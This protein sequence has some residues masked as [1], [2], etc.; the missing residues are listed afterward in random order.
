[1]K[2]T[3]MQSTMRVDGAYA[4]EIGEYAVVTEF[5]EVYR[6]PFPEMWQV[7]E[8]QTDGKVEVTEDLLDLAAMHNSIGASM[9]EDRKEMGQEEFIDEDADGQ[10]VIEELMQN[11]PQEEPP[12]QVTVNASMKHD[13]MLGWEVFPGTYLLE[14]GRITSRIPGDEVEPAEGEFLVPF[15]AYFYA[16][17]T[18]EKLRIVAESEKNGEAGYID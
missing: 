10:W 3:I 13:G 5:G 1:M 2:K 9:D 7:E 18:A 14:N 4:V 12:T 16:Q 6:K 17:D 15:D 8:D 11:E